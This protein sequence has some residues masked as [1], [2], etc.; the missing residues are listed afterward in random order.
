MKMMRR[1]FTLFAI[2]SMVVVLI[3]GILC[4]MTIS[5]YRKFIIFSHQETFDLSSLQ[6]LKE[7]DL[8]PADFYNAYKKYLSEYKESSKSDSLIGNR[9][10]FSKT[11]SLSDT[12]T[13]KLDKKV[14]EG[15]FFINSQRAGMNTLCRTTS[16]VKVVDRLVGYVAGKPLIFPA[17]G[18]L[19]KSCEDS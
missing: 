3:V 11:V 15:R 12:H 19:L 4:Y 14:A 2:E 10:I 1:G 7:S 16:R 9:N 8:I 6:Q 17:S 13:L 5:T 18:P